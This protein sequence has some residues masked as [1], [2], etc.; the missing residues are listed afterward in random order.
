[1]STFYTTPEYAPIETVTTATYTFSVADHGGTVYL[2]RTAGTT[3]T[4]PPGLP[5]GWKCRVLVASTVTTT[6]TIAMGS[7]V[8]GLSPGGFGAA[9]WSLS[10]GGVVDLFVVSSNLVT[11]MPAAGAA[12]LNAMPTRVANVPI[13]PVAR[14]SLGTDAVS[15]AGTIY[16]SDMRLDAPMVATGMGVLNGTTAATDKVVYA[17]WDSAGAVIRTTLLT[18][19]LAANGDVFQEI[20]FTSA[21]TLPPG[22]YWGGFQAEGTTT[23]HQTIATLTY[24]NSTGSV[25][26]VFGTVPAITPTTSTTAG[27]G[28]FWYLY[29]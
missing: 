12:A 23:A 11:A 25:A 9:P 14:A 16:F 24:L 17:L 1:M 27:V 7:G 5:V 15:V 6:P 10:A 29:T 8:T 18:G 20:A 4:V 26:G 22:R 19:V 21:V 28:P 2:T 3:A 13:G